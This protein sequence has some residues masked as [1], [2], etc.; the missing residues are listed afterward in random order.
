MCQL[1][2]SESLL[3]IFFAFEKNGD[4]NDDPGTPSLCWPL[5]SCLYIIC[6]SC[7]IEDF[8][9]VYLYKSQGDHVLMDE[10]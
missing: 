9:N 2:A 5:F 1:S 3:R 10:Q 8:D 6:C 7:F 4:E